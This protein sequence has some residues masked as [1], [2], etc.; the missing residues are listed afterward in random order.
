VS[1]A[2][3]TAEQQD[4][5]ATIRNFVDRDVAPNVSRLDHAD[6]FPTELVETMKELGLFGVT[7]PG[8]T[9]GWGSTSPPTRSSSPSCHGGGSRCRGS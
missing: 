9:G 3:L 8:S 7:I 6:E 5:L 2:D 1:T 4:I